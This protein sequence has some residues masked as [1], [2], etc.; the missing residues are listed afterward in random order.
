MEVILKGLKKNNSSVSTLRRKT[1]AVEIFLTINDEISLNFEKHFKKYNF[2]VCTNMLIFPGVCCPHTLVVY[3]P[4]RTSNILT[5]PRV[6]NVV[7]PDIRPADISAAV[8]S[9]KKY[10]II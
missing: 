6:P 2:D 10:L 5:A 4:P 8:N 3:E 7:I 9:G 1:Q